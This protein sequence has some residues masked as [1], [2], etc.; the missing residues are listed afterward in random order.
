MIEQQLMKLELLKSS[1][2][3]RKTKEYIKNKKC[4]MGV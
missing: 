1:K 3:D 2:K 4:G